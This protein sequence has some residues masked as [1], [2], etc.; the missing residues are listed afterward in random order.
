MKVGLVGFAGSG[1]T[2]VF[3]TMTGLAVPTGYGG[4]LRLALSCGAQ[5]STIVYSGVAKRDD[6]I[7]LA[8]GKSIRAIHAESVEELHRVS[9]RAK[10]AGTT[11]RVGLRIN[12]S[13]EADTHAHIATGHDEA[14]RATVKQYKPDAMNVVGLALR[15]D[16]KLV[17]KITKGARMH[18]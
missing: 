13:V 11:A 5:P 12:P 6:E 10:A 17:D 18:G 8:L 3:N 14:N 4:E 9:A 15:D 16:K 2:T 1:K 7:D